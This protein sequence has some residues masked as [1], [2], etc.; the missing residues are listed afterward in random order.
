MMSS[1]GTWTPRAY[2]LR[3]FLLAAVFLFAWYQMYQMSFPE[4]CRGV[5]FHEMSDACQ[6]QTVRAS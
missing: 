6:R 1:K 3:N 4:E 2:R 5:A